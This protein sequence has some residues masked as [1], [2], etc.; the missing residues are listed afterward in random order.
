MTLLSVNLNKIALVRNTRT[1]GIPSVV[2]FARIA[3]AAGAQGI[4]IHPRPDGR[5]IRP[6]DVSDLA[7]TLIDW[8][9][10]DFNIEGNPFHGLLEFVRKFRPQQC[11]LVPDESVRGRRALASEY[12]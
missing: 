6:H 10:T 12:C 3:L 5:H 2:K 7:D 11:T 8:P 1:L 9:N 4:T